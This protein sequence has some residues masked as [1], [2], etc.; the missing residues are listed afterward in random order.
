MHIGTEDPWALTELA[1]A[2]GAWECLG[3]YPPSR[4]FASQCLGL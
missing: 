4:L 2:A 1:K 3:G